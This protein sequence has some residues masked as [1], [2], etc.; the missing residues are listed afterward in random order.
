MSADKHL[1]EIYCQEKQRNGESGVRR[2]LCFN[3]E[4]YQFLFV[5]WWELASREGRQTILSRRD[6]LNGKEK[7]LGF[8]WQLSS[9][10]SFPLGSFLEVLQETY[11]ILYLETYNKCFFLK[12]KNS[13]FWWCQAGAVVNSKVGQSL[14]SVGTRTIL[15]LKS[16]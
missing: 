10:L 8:K 2:K 5:C 13:R 3:W 4:K 6:G 11:L 12:K 9:K 16:F 7:G 1:Q 15:I 14:D